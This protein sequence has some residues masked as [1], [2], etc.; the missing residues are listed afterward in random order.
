MD[1]ERL[2]RFLNELAAH[3][4][5]AAAT[6]GVMMRDVA[7]NTPLHI[8]AL[9]GDPGVARALLDGGADA[10]AVGADGNTPLHAALAQ[11]HL[12]VARMLIAAGGALDATNH[13]G[14]SARAMPHAASLWEAES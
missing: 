13:H 12:Q 7:N 8:A 2:S 4:D 5:F 11:A 3:P 14:V 6:A 10:N 1:T 9:R